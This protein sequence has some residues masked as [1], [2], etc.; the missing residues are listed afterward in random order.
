MII[1]DLTEMAEK[2]RASKKKFTL[3]CCMA[4][5]CM[6]SNSKVKSL[7]KAVKKRAADQVERR[8]RP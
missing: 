3:H 1:D 5:G 8:G 2:E 6:S 7:D 4:A